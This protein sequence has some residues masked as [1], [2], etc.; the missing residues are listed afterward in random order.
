MGGATCVH[1]LPQHEGGRWVGLPVCI[2]YSNLHPKQDAFWQHV[3]M[4]AQLSSTFPLGCPVKVAEEL[5]RLAFSMDENRLAQLKAHSRQ[6][7]AER[8]KQGALRAQEEERRTL[9]L[10][11]VFSRW[12]LPGEADLPLLQVSGAD[13]QVHL[14][15]LKQ[16]IQ[17]FGGP[18]KGFVLFRKLQ[19]H[20]EFASLGGEQ[21]WAQGLMD[22][23]DLSLLFAQPL[24][25][26]IRSAGYK[27]PGPPPLLYFPG[28]C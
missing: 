3:T 17:L 5:K 26:H 12:T 18:C 22:F 4:A 28:I 23:I 20:I 13:L 14:L 21:I 7:R 24:L 16:H 2:V 9:A 11:A 25:Q 27:P 6:R 8:E 19:N 15:A 10:R 1:V